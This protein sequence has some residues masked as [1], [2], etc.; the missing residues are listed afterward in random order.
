M[1]MNF[2]TNYSRLKDYIL[3]YKWW[4]IV[5][6]LSS[7]IFDS[8]SLIIPWIL[9]LSIESLKKKADFKYV[10]YYVSIIIS[11]ALLGALF[12]VISRY[13]IFG[14]SRYIEND[15]RED[16]FSHLLKQSSSF[17]QKRKTGDIISRATND[18]S[19]VRM[20]IGFGMLTVVST[21]FTYIFAATAMIT[22]SLK[23]TL[24]ALL[25]YPIIFFIVK[26]VT[27]VMFKVSKKL[28]E[29]LGEVSSR[30]QENVSGIHV[31]K[32]YVQ[33][34]NEEKSFLDLNIDY[35]R[36]KMKMV[37]IMGALF[38]LMGTLG[39]IGTLII[40]WQ[41]G[42]M[43]I[44][45]EISLGDFVAFNGYLALLIW[46]SIA[47]GWIF[48]LIQRGLAS[49]ERICE[50]LRENPTIADSPETLPVEKISGELEFRNLNFSYPAKQN[51][52]NSFIE[53]L[54][55]INLKISR[56]EF[57]AVVGRTG[58]GKS[59]LAK[60]LLRLLEIEEGKIFIDGTDI[61]K[62]PLNVLR[63]NI[64]YVPQES[65]LFNATIRENIA[66][67]IEGNGLEGNNDYMIERASAI[68]DL[69]KDVEN[70]PKRFET[71]IGERGINISGGQKQRIS[72]ART[73]ILPASVLVFDDPLSS[74]DAHTEKA[75]LEKIK[76][77][78][79][80][81]TTLFITHRI[82][83]IKDADRI[84]VM[85]D[86]EIREIGVHEELMALNG[87]YY[88]LYNQQLL[89]EELEEV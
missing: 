85:E 57:I 73:I 7:V 28:Q 83:S 31:V 26:I 58:A 34:E 60:L 32:S 52:N 67:G 40:L 69:S 61:T 65:F 48:T 66:Y 13:L 68:A 55:N 2:K 21:C 22:L 20:F 27:P 16:L 35:F 12:R 86:G 62:I 4:F 36:N 23:L 39:G 70:F 64:G 49:F 9:K 53:V 18:L 84:I 30:V 50:I 37:R 56:G 38:P 24:F 8:T 46:P 71:L 19:T 42:R 1:Q 43:V 17:Y 77:M 41:G 63:K 51:G 75:I 29:Q 81:I 79:R 89:M 3:H 78:A 82:P 54:K 6:I 5:G 47:L 44:L 74:V 88:D 59:T 80:G 33:E 45:G 72:F 11:L 15:V 76:E 10:T 87:T 25:P 14:A